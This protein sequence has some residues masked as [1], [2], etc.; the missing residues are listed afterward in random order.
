MNGKYNIN[1]IRKLSNFSNNNP[2]KPSNTFIEERNLINTNFSVNTSPLYVC[3]RKTVP[4]KKTT[5]NEIRNQQKTFIHSTIN[6]EEKSTRCIKTVPMKNGS[7]SNYIDIKEVKLSEKRSRIDSDLKSVVLPN[8][9]HFSF[10]NKSPKKGNNSSSLLS[11]KDDSLK[12]NEKSAQYNCYICNWEFPSNMLLEEKEAHLNKCLDDQGIDDQTNYFKSLE[13]A[14]EIDNVFIS[15]V[16]ET[17][18][19]FCFKQLP[20]NKERHMKRC[21]NKIINT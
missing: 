3:A 6:V 8:S 4:Y 18:C 17:I 12:K 5:N 20:L 7:N 2:E 14:K 13:T 9:S 21:S 15:E 19:P 1:D 10:S 16:T 11:I